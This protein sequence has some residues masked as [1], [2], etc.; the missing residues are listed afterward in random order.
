MT[1]NN[2]SKYFQIS[3]LRMFGNSERTLPNPPTPNRKVLFINLQSMILNSVTHLLNT[4]YFQCV[5]RKK[6]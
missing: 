4:M 3:V 2:A 5:G 6:T 1:Q